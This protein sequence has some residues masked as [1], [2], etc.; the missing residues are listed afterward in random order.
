MADLPEALFRKVSRMPR[1]RAHPQKLLQRALPPNNPT[2]S[3]TFKQPT[4]HHFL[5]LPHQDAGLNFFAI[6]KPHT[7]HNGT[8]HPGKLDRTALLFQA[9]KESQKPWLPDL[10]YTLQVFHHF[11]AYRRN[12]DE[13]F[14]WGTFQW[15][16]ENS[17][18]RFSRFA[19]HV[20]KARQEGNKGKGHQEGMSLSNKTF[21][22]SLFLSS[23]NSSEETRL[24]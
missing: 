13:G 6:A 20:G 17:R 18:L 1:F 22:L 11:W 7:R 23:L 16:G 8:N 2:T 21:S 10:R 5:S 15:P 14:F 4:H 3:Q 12:G 9:L 19:N 24:F